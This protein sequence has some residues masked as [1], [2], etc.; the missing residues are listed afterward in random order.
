[1]LALT[2]VAVVLLAVAAATFTL[3]YGGIHVIV[4]GA[5]VPARMARYYPGLLDAA[6]VVACLAAV[7][8][9]DGRWW[10]RFYA[11]LAILVIVVVGGA[12]SAVHAMNLVLPH[13]Q[14][15]GAV[16]AAPWVLLL[17]SFSLW[18]TALR[19]SRA[20]RELSPA[21]EARSGEETDVPVSGQVWPR[22]YW[23]VDEAEDAQA[24][25]MLSAPPES[26]ESPPESPSEVHHLNRPRSL[27]APPDGPEDNA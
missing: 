2:G 11:W 19:H 15:A 17:L 1:M 27:P 14:T 10:A 6:L 24:D 4:L 13:R 12:A 7:M 3:S 5:G 21:G 26:P 22:D 18:L 25:P 8:L 23:D 16:A 20:R 9:R